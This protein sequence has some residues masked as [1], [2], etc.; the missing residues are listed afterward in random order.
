[1]A[2]TLISPGVLARENDQSFITQQPVQIGAAI[3]GPAVKGPVEQPTIVTSYSDYQNR[4]GTI[5]ESGSI[6]YTF[7]TSIAAYNYFNNGG[8]A[9]LVTRV[10]NSPS[11]WNYASASIKSGVNESGVLELLPNNLLGSITS[12]PTNAGAATYTG[13]SLTGGSGTGAEATVVVT[14]TTAPTITSITATDGGTGYEVGD[15]L[16]IA[17][18]DLGTGQLING[19]NVLAI[20]GG[21][22]NLG[23]AAG[24]NTVAQS[25]ATGVGTGA[26]FVITG[27]GA[28]GVLA[29]VV[30]AIGTGYANGDVITITGTD[31]ANEGFT[32]ATGNLTITLTAAQIQDSSA[33]T[34]TLTADNIVN[35]TAFELEAIDKGVIW[36]NT[37]SVL[38]DNAME[39]GSADNVRWEVTTANTSSG[40]FSLIVRRGNDTQN[41]KVVLESWNN[42]SLDPTQDNFITKVIGDEKYN[43]ISA[44]NYLQVS[45][46]YRNASR[47]IRVKSVNLTTPGYLDN[48]GNAKDQYTG[49]IPMAGSGSYNGSFAG[50]AG[51]I[52]PTGRTMNMYQNINATDSQG[53]VG[54]DYTNM[55]NLLSNQDNYQFNSLFLPGLTNATHASQITTAI[56]NTQQRG[57]SILVID[58]VTYASA[59]SSVTNAADNRNTSYAAMYWP[60]LQVA[61]PDLSNTTNVWVP[62][63]TMIAGVYAYNDS[64][65]EPW[66]A[67]AGI[68]R[69]GLTNV[70]RAERPLTSTNRDTLYESN[71]NPIA[72][73]PGTG[74]VVYGQKTLQKQA[75]ALDRVNVRRLL[76]AL[77]SYI[78]QVAQTLVFEQ[79]TAATRNNFLAAVNPYLESVQQRQGLYAFKVV[80][81]DSNN[82]PDVIDRNQLVGAIYLQPTRTA[83]FI[84]LDFNVLPTGA[85]FPA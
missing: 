2:E 43:Y 42:L 37:G 75:S 69:G 58:P 10:V 67:P 32:G 27:D 33:A 6:D 13:V 73:F 79:N 7:F 40:T 59:I 34:I 57:D 64:V 63:S 41:N 47:Y 70:V 20:I 31:L 84:Y 46:S 36:N 48:A 78:G 29:I 66:F 77:K 26:S 5:F 38:A 8:N 49:S 15:V 60:W 12:N 25:S 18:A 74:V 76:I 80:M 85:T 17:A 30:S 54:S 28:G 56:N 21:T 1:M 61:D 23:T 55:L 82:T 3:V 16:T 35:A 39:S 81:D 4:F 44:D 11:S 9:L 71:V 22:Y 24:P 53:L 65:S 19:D 52:I 72:S 45:G 51:N 14:G 68:N 62:A 50:G 83:E